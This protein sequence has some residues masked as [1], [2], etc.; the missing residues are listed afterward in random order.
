MVLVQPTEGSFGEETLKDNSLDA[1]EETYSRMTRTCKYI[2]ECND[3]MVCMPH[4]N[5]FIFMGT[6]RGELKWYMLSFVVLTHDQIPGRPLVLR[7]FG[8]NLLC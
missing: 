2:R 4:H 8:A 7:F 1:M 5:L 3:S 6:R